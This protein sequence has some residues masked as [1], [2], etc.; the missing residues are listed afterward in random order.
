MSNFSKRADWVVA[1]VVVAI[2]VHVVSSFVFLAV[3]GGG[4]RWSLLPVVST[5]IKRREGHT[6]TPLLSI[7]GPYEA[8]SHSGSRRTFI[9]EIASA[10][11][12]AWC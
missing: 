9:P 2:V 10:S 12:V 8:D 1:R 4:C 7:L 6:C 5:K 11:F 3:M